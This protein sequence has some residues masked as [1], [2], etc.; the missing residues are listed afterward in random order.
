MYL[1][2]FEDVW[3]PSNHILTILQDFMRQ[4]QAQYPF[5]QD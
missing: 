5:A 3:S 4:S 2:L 1:H